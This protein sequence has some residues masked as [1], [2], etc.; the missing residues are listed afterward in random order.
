MK[1]DKLISC[2]AC[3]AKL[4]RAARFCPQCGHPPAKS[5]DWLR[6]PIALGSILFYGLGI[7]AT[8]EVLQK[9]TRGVD[10]S[11]LEIGTVTQLIICAALLHLV[12]RR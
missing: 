8:F 7:Y 3:E 10:I 5:S 11:V 12:A 1:D 9:A 6:I 4:S 2:A